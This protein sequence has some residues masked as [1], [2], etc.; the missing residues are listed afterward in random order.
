MLND[1]ISPASEE[2]WN[3]PTETQKE[4]VDQELNDDIPPA[5]EEQWN[6]T[7]ETQNDPPTA[8]EILSSS[9]PAA[10]DPKLDERQARVQAINQRIQEDL[11]T[12]DEAEARR[13]ADLLAT[14]K[15]GS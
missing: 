15:E 12:R 13:K 9:S 3:L 14:G 2:Q 4:P 5:N 7:E 6:T 1:F 11:A 8:E 10:E